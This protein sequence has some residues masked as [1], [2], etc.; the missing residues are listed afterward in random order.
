MNTI[1]EDGVFYFAAGE[2]MRFIKLLE[3]NY[4]KSLTFIS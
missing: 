3:P 2:I 1:S 4:H